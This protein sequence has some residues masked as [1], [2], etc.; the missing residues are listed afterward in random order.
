MS[1]WAIVTAGGSGSRFGAPKQ[2]RVLGGVTLLERAVDAVSVHADGVVV[3]LP[4]GDVVDLPSSVVR[5]EGGPTRLASVRAA[6]AAVPPSAQVIVIHGPSHP[7]AGAHLT[8]AVI[9]A[10]RAGADA[11]IPGLPVLDALKRV[12]EG[13][14]AASVDK[15]GV[16]L[17]QTP[18]AFRA[19]A[20]RAVH[21]DR[22]DAAEDSELIERA[23]GRVVVVPGD[24]ANLHIATP[25]DLA[26]AERLV[27]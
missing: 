1:T 9:A 18:Q 22:P 15:S 6:L 5:V 25:A 2:Y 8:A 7:L 27:R 26:L 16:V 12:S 24:P 17:A 20:L 21:A 23:G 14:V 4:A 3:A 13:V 10:V 11:A 19:A